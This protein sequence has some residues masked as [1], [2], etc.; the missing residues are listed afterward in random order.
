MG[1]NNVDL[2]FWYSH[3]ELQCWGLYVLHTRLG[4]LGRGAIGMSRLK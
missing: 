1:K 4:D 3:E 2:K